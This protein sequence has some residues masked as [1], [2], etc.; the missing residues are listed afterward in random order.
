MFSGARENYSHANECV[1]WSILS[2]GRAIRSFVR[3]K[4]HLTWS[5]EAKA[6]DRR[7]INELRTIGTRLFLDLH[8]FQ[9]K[10]VIIGI[11]NLSLLC[12]WEMLV[13]YPLDARKYH[14]KCITLGSFV[15]HFNKFAR[16]RMVKFS[17][18]DGTFP[19]DEPT[20]TVTSLGT[21]LSGLSAMEFMGL[22]PPPP[23][24]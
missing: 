16:H 11:A 4:S 19:S 14:I 1:V 15:V 23:A 6:N 10:E 24:K 17:R 8:L 7:I 5:D 12:S 18:T 20:A 22:S 21:P 13:L 2:W 9:E 3:S